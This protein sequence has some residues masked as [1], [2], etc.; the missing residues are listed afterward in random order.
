[1]GEAT[2]DNARRRNAFLHFFTYEVVKVVAGAE[3][4]RFIVGLRK[5]AEG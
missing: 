4:A 2:E 1:M 5:F 3:D